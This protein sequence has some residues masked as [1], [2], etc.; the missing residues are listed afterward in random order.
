MRIRLL[1]KITFT[2]FLFGPLLILQAKIEGVNFS[3]LRDK[4]LKFLY[5]NI[6]KIENLKGKNRKIPLQKHLNF[7]GK[8]AE[9]SFEIFS[10]KFC[11]QSA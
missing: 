10:Q 5:K 6:E 9:K 2:V 3:F 1:V 11:L 7:K 4:C 8:S